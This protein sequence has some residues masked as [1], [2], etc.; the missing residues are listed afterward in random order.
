MGK[1]E[2]AQANALYQ[3]GAYSAA[4]A[5]YERVAQRPGWDSLVHANMVLCR[6]RLQENPA[7]KEVEPPEIIVA[8]TTTRS[9]LQG[10]PKVVD[11]LLEQ[12]LKPFRIDLNISRQ[13]DMSD[14]G[15]APDDP[16]LVELTRIPGLNISWV[17]NI[18]SYRKIWPLLEGHF[19]QVVAGDRLFVTVDD[20]T[21]Y[22]ADFLQ[23]LYEN[24]LRYN[25]VISFRG[26]HMELDQDGRLSLDDRWTMGK[27]VPSLGN[28]P[29]GQNGV[30]YSTKFFVKDFL[31]FSQAQLLAP[32]SDELWVKWHC[33]LNGVPTVVLEP[34]DCPTFEGNNSLIARLEAHYEQTCNYN[35][36][37]LIRA[38]LKAAA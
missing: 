28:L 10:V 21:P 18:G 36:A 38:E 19:S 2:T 30:F 35:L 16:V 3:A 31:N 37:W 22:P 7:K 14:E 17:P 29:C 33:A 24:Y 27:N 25:C 1:G 12:T 23:L 15:I 8:L 34:G 13:S 26:W 4:L 11:S 6:Q 9:R 32:M 20:N 5:L